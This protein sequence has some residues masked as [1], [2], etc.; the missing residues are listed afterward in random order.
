MQHFSS[1]PSVQP[2]A[3]AQPMNPN[4][5]QAPSTILS[6]G[7]GTV[8]TALSFSSVPGTYL[9][10][11]LVAVSLNLGPNERIVVPV[12]FETSFEF[13]PKTLSKLYPPTGHWIKA[14]L[15]MEYL[16]RGGVIFNPENKTNRV[17]TQKEAKQIFEYALTR[18]QVDAKT[19]R[20]IMMGLG[21]STGKSVWKNPSLVVNPAP[22]PKSPP[23][24]MPP[25]PK[26]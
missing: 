18:L 11:V 9:V 22:V 8:N 1:G 12:E 6:D 15:V 19:I 16:A 4:P 13:F 10:R 21:V 7:F 26:R 20:A 3:G 14:A 2:M 24:N 17:P 23:L 5:T 25:L